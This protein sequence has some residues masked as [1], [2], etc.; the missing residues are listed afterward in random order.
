MSIEAKQLLL[1]DF[2]R[3]IGGV[4]TMIQSDQVMEMLSEELSSYEI[5]KNESEELDIEG[6]EL[7][8]AYITAK[9]IEGRS[10]KTMERYRYIIEK[11]MKK[12]DVPI[13]KIS[14]FHI[15]RY[16]TEEKDRGISDRTLEGTR[17]VLSAYFNWLHKEGLIQTN[18]MVNLGAIKYQKVER[19][20]Y[21]LVDIEK[22]KENCDNYRDKAIISFLL[23]T[24]CRISEACNLNRDD[25]DYANKECR[26]LGKGNKERTVFLDDVTIM[27]LKRYVDSRDDN[28]EALFLSGRKKKRITPSGVRYAL[29]KIADKASVE[30]T[31]PHRFRRTL[32]TNLINHGMPIQE[33]ASLL[34]HEKI[35][36]TMTYV[37]IDKHNVK[38]SYKKYM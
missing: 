38:N 6:G 20:P 30:N 31:H 15:R 19:Q 23:S 3:K 1:H 17:E 2:Q 33:V 36:T 22:L 12:I 10:E 25:V 28:N 16:F 13:R 14:V 9:R 27:L 37:Y 29:H 7:L 4:L 32:A 11:M 26:V 21:S 24:G 18:P 8:E 34:G 5:E 35:D